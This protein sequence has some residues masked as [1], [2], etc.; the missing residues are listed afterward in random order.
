MMAQSFRSVAQR[1][2]GALKPGEPRPADPHGSG[3]TFETVT[4]RYIA[5][6]E[7]RWG[8]HADAT[9]K[10]IIRKHLIA[11]LGTRPVNELSFDE[12]QKVIDGMVLRNASHSLL[13]KVVTHLRGIL[14]LAQESGDIARSPLRSRAYKIKYKSLRPKSER[15]LTLPECG[16][17]LA[18]CFGRDRLIV[19]ILLQL[20]LRPQELFALRRDDVGHESLRIDEVL[21][22]G[23]KLQVRPQTVVVQTYVP[24][25]L[26]AELRAY[27]D[28]APGASRDWL[29]PGVLSRRS[30][31]VLPISQNYY[32]NQILRPLARRAG[33]LNL[34]FLTL[35]RTC[36]LHSRQ[37][38]SVRAPSDAAEIPESMKNAAQALEADLLGNRAR[39]QSP[40]LE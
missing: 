7:P 32:R 16:E 13:H 36:A 10:S 12:I 20:G 1:I 39:T 6:M 33:I 27:L 28:A 24:P 37:Q 31:A 9:A 21:A 3:V 11:D 2:F 22:R 26:M 35:R 34:D 4:R 18:R 5:A 29:F 30:G 17:L 8:P 23:L 19:R 38:A 25:G 40:A 14:D 15:C